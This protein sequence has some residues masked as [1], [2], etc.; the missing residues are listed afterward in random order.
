MSDAE[1]RPVTASGWGLSEER[2]VTSTGRVLSEEEIQQLA[3]EAEA[4][5]DVSKL[6]PRSVPGAVLPRAFV[7]Q[8]LSEGILT[9]FRKGSDCAL[10][11]EVWARIDLMPNEDWSA[12]VTYLVDAMEQT[13]VSWVRKERR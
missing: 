5:Y 11:R 8:F 13:G 1:P 10:A 2:Y 6:V 9:A 7:E 12:V 3:D 4:G